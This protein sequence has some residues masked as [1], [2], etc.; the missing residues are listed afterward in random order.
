MGKLT[1]AEKIRELL[2]T[3][4]EVKRDYLFKNEWKYSN[5]YPCYF[6]LWEH[7]KLGYKG[8][9]TDIAFSIQVCLHERKK[10]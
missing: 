10:T 3:V 9:S 1:T 7:G 4:E 5:A 8:V 2:A 6:W